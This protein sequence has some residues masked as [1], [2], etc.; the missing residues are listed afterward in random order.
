MPTIND[1][2]VPRTQTQWFNDLLERLRTA[3]NLNQAVIGDIS[4]WESGAIYRTLLEM[5]SAALADLDALIPVIVE[6]A[7]IETS[8][9]L[10]LDLK[11]ISDYALAREDAVNTVGKVKL[12][13]TGATGPHNFRAAELWATSSEGKRFLILEAGTIPLSGSVI[14]TARAESAGAD[15]NVA[16]GAITALVTPIPGVTVSN[17]AIVGST[18]PTWLVTAGADVER[19]ERLRQRCKGRWAS[20]SD[21]GPRAALEFWA[22]QASS[23]VTKVLVR[24]QHPRGQGTVDVVIYGDGGLGVGVLATVDTVLQDHR[25]VTA[26][27]LTLSATEVTQTITAT[28]T[29]RAASRALAEA[30]VIKNLLALERATPIE[31]TLYRAAIYEA[32]MQAPGMVNTVIATPSSDLILTT[33]QVVKLLSSLTWVE[34]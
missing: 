20:R 12:Q 27:L 4:D 33:N 7:Y 13:D 24:D 1:L 5:D 8:S 29:V 6:N 22:R 23:S 17:P 19:D 30:Q 16:T 26:D 10:W 2:L 9:G 14:V 25:P 3:A 18:P 31:G 34:V 21:A 32:L 11:A 28:Q 15:W